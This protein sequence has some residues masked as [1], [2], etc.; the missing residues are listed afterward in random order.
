MDHLSKR[1]RHAQS[2]PLGIAKVDVEG[3]YDQKLWMTT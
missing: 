3:R 2:K 1:L